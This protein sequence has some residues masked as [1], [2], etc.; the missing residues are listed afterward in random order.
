MFS[1]I[2]AH[3]DAYGIG[4][5]GKIPWNCP[6]DI[7]Y[8]KSM[9]INQVIIMG[10][11]TYESIGKPL[12]KRI[13]IV[14]SRNEEFIKKL[15]DNVLHFKDPID[16]VKHCYKIDQLNKTFKYEKSS[17]EK[18]SIEKSSIEKK[19]YTN[20]RDTSLLDS[21]DHNQDA[22]RIYSSVFG[23]TLSTI[24]MK[25]YI[26]DTDYYSKFFV[27]GGSEI[28]NWF[29]N[30]NF[31]TDMYVTNIYSRYNCDTY[32]DI[33]RAK[34]KIMNTN[35]KDT[36]TITH[37]KSINAEEEKMLEVMSRIL[38]EGVI[39]TDRTGV[40]TISKFGMQLNFSLADHSFPLMTTRP[41]F[42]RGIFEELMLYIRGQTDS[43]ILED[44]KINVW[45]PNTTRQ[46]LDSKGLQHLPVGDMGPSYG[47]LFRHFGA[48]YT[49]CLADY[50]GKGTDQ[51]AILID[52]LKNNPSDRR[53][54]ISLWDPSMI[55]KCPLP[56][57]L[58]NYQF[59]VNDKKLSCMMTQRS[60]DIAV[61]GGWNVA[62]GA[63]LTIMLAASCNLVPDEL[64][65]NI[66]DAHIYKNLIEQVK[67][68]LTRTPYP[69]PKLFL[70][71]KNDITDYQF[72][73]LTL[74]GYQTHPQI[75]LTMNA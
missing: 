20:L 29:I 19:S 21:H 44:K 28:Y 50:T 16:A 25:H 10:R 24:P 58:Y 65:W 52:K 46:F 59:Y 62:T 6:D 15:P 11:K 73:D 74:V 13:N 1:L 51:L 4:K 63:L 68:Q 3:D 8:F 60:S 71:K 48:T 5:N 53:L 17:I 30:K 32:L 39:K 27:I 36:H 67:E 14:I 70:N 56:P 31:I 35:V 9:T 41:M 2:V 33:N 64:I 22:S 26:Q 75:K 40:G 34:L 49:N 12:P 47:F 37:Y 45:K 72:D 55:D 7:K 61:A 66:G 54:I 18:S 38:S 23:K 57:C 43:K 69:Y 42:L